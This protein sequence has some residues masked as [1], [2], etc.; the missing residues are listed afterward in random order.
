MSDTAQNTDLV[1][2]VFS[3]FKGYLTSQFE[4]KDKH[5]HE[6][7]KIVKE[8]NE[9]KF[10]GNRKQFELNANLNR[11]LSQISANIN[12]LLEIQKSVDEGQGLIKKRQ[13]QIKLV[14]QSKDGWQVVQE[15]ESDDLASNSED[16]KRIRDATTAVEK[17]RKEAKS[18]LGSASKRFRP[19][20]ADNQLFCGMIVTVLCDSHSGWVA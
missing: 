15:Y 4:A 1:E 17:K 13:K 3:M 5:R 12:N 18:Q 16:E 14:D 6:E 20:A 11:I 10:K 19:A 7:S 9:L 8:A 2:Q